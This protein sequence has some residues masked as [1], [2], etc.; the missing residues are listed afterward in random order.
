MSIG[1]SLLTACASSRVHV[2]PPK[3]AAI[4]GELM[5]PASDPVAG[6]SK[7]AGRPAAQAEAW[8]RDR[9]ALATCKARLGGLQAIVQTERSVLM[10]LREEEP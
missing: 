8:G 4:P 7:L 3:L 9:A 10:Q 2:E 1:A 5:Q 6:V